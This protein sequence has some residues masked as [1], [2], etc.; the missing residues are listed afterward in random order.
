[1]PLGGSHGSGNTE[2]LCRAAW[3]SLASRERV[4]QSR[5]G[6]LCRS[7]A[8]GW[9]QLQPE[10]LLFVAGME[11]G[12]TSCPRRRLSLRS[13]SSLFRKAADSFKREDYFGITNLVEHPAQLSPPG[14]VLGVG[15]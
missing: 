4:T 14:E 10:P 13:F 8:V 2:E 3:W 15:P 12:G 11:G 6:A 9:L 7:A 5:A 1:M